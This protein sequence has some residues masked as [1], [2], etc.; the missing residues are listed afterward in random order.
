MGGSGGGKQTTNTSNTIAP[1]L[2]PLFQNTADLI[3]N[4]QPGIGNQFGQ[5]FGN[6]A[7]QIP[8]FTG[9]QQQ[10]SDVQFA[11]AMSGN[12][13]SAYEM[14]AA[15][16]G[17]GAGGAT[18]PEQAALAQIS[19]LQNTPFGT[20]PTTQAA[21]AAARNPALNELAAAG[22][23]NS[24]AIG[25][26]LAG[27]YAPI[28]AQEMAFRQQAV[29]QLANIGGAMAAR[30]LAGAQL[31]NQIGAMGQQRYSDLINQSMGSQEQMRQI[32]EAQ[33]AA[34]LQ[35]LLRRQGLG[36]QFTTGILSGFPAL[37]GTSSVTRTTGGQ[38]K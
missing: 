4:L 11:R 3:T 5:F 18:A 15:N 36:T 33:G 7:Q 25:T 19:Q 16:Y 27:A 22:L 37:S 23:G 26:S 34:N 17:A 12:P 9:G 13:L 6:Q 2:S 1:E 31:E 35:D 30:G 8:G 29:P 10:L 32:G 21:I 28:Y 38:S 24:D 20:L 14:Q